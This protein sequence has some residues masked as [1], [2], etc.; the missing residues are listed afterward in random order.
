[1]TRYSASLYLDK[2]E[3]QKNKIKIATEDN[4]KLLGGSAGLEIDEFGS[5]LCRTC[6]LFLSY[7]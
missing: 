5:D 1:M 2:R 7:V 3:A 4:V 6:T